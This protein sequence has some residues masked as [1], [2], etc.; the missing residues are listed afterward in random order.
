MDAI[1]TIG[2]GPVDTRATRPSL[3]RHVAKLAA[4]SAFLIYLAEAGS[5][6]LTVNQLAFFMLAASAE[7]AG[8][9]ATYSEIM[10]DAEGLTQSGLKNSYRQL[11]EPSRAFPSALGWLCVEENPADAR[12]KVLRLSQDGYDVVSAAL[13]ALEPITKGGRA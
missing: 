4:S 12:E 7:A 2:G 9:P 11:L 5:H 13:L 3:W 1:R 10:A 6:R 8:K